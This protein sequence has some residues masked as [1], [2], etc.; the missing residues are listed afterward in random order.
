MGTLTK[1]AKNNVIKNISKYFSVK[2]KKSWKLFFLLLPFLVFVTVFSY[3]PLFGWSYAFVDYTPGLK[4]SE[5]RFIGLK[6]FITVFSGGSAFQT[7]MINTLAIGG[8]SLLCSVVPV[9]FA[10]MVSQIDSR[11]YSRIIQS[12][13]SI[14]NFISWV[15]VYAIVFSLFASD[16]GVVNQVLMKIGLIN[17]PIDILG[18]EQYAWFIQIG[19][20]IWKSTG[21]GAIVYLAA[22]A[23]ID[24]A[25]YEAASIDGANRFQKIIHITLPGV[26]STYL[27][28]FLLAVA[29]ILS[30]GFDQFWVFQNALTRD[31]LEVFDTYVYRLGMIN[32]EYS[33]ST[34]MGILK[35]IVSVMLLFI[36]NYIAKRIRG[37]SI[38]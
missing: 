16:S 20:G 15:L 37:E 29:G 24:P 7:V 28:L 25:L 34:A 33:F 30:N 1:K 2:Y 14:P 26:A 11:R 31:K 21:W 17:T 6:N 19:I 10:I 8:L 13:T 35:S 12:I 18:N 23:G 4:L 22:I 5:M 9:I 32:K 3:I 27:V 38:V 36:S